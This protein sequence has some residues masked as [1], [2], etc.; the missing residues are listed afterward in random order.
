[1]RKY[2]KAYSLRELRQFQNWKEKQTERGTELADDLIVYLWDDFTV[3]ES[4]ILNQ[5]NLFDNVTS[6]WQE[7]CRN[8]LKFAI[9][10]DL[11]YVYQE[12]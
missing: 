2:C 11:Q 9:P 1:M 3:V 10:E 7:F 8:T 4:P 5:R 12:E 6:E